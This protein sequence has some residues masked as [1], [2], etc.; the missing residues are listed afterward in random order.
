MDAR[1]SEQN[2]K[3]ADALYREGRYG[4]ALG[5]L[6]ELNRAHPNAKNVLYPAALCLEKLGRGD[7]ALPICGQLIAQFQ[8]PRARELQARLT[9]ASRSGAGEFE[10]TA[11]ADLGLHGAGD[12]LDMGP[13]RRV[14]AYAA[15]EPEGDWK[16]YALIGLGVAAVLAL[17]VIPPLMYEAPSEPPPGRGGQ[18]GV[19]IDPEAFLGAIGIGFFI[20][21]LG[22]GLVGHIAGGYLALSLMNQLPSD[23]AS[24]NLISIGL[25]V[26]VVFLVGFV[27]VVGG[28]IGLIIISKNYDLGCGGL[29][30]YVFLAGFCAFLFMMVPL[31]L[32][33]GS[34][35]ALAPSAG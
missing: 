26:L 28:V 33:A 5:I 8:D 4:E 13:P 22:S 15:A 25:T 14:A 32:M 21:F 3:R 17:I 30:I 18:G 6:D 9:A 34:L 7:E 12:I 31:M 27:P 24:D 23:R 1:E 29:L 2:F 11:L 16:R 10:S 19:G 20:L 35:A